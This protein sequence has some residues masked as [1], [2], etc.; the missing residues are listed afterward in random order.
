MAWNGTVTCSECWREGHNRNGCPRRKERYEEALAMPHEERG[1][2]E[3]R[4]IDEWEHKRKVAAS[5]KCSYCNEQGHNRRSCAK[6]KEH[7]AIIAEMNRDYRVKLVEWVREQGLNA[8]AL[9][10]TT[11]STL[12]FVSGFAWDNINIWQGEIPR[13]IFA[14]PVSALGDRYDCQYTITDNPDWPTGTKWK[15]SESYSAR[16]YGAEVVGPVATPAAAP[17][18]WAEDT[19]PV[20]EYFKSRR[21][22]D[23]TEDTSHYNSHDWWKL[24]TEEDQELKESA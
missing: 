16:S 7:F 23:W 12:Y 8:G 18:G 20:K 3:R 9:I 15:H 13:F 5:R 14:K 24:D 6:L 4:I 10:R 19:Q 17:D 21:L 1:Y 11:E 22:Y 2:G